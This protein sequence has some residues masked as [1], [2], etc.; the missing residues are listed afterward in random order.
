MRMPEFITFTGPDDRTD[1]ADLAA[2]LALARDYPVE[3]AVLFSADRAGTAR[4][5]SLDWSDGVQRLG[6]PRLAAHLCGGYAKELVATGG[7]G[8]DAHLGGFDRIQVNTAASVSP[9]LVRAWTDALARRGGHPVEPILQCRGP[10]PEDSR[11]T[12]LYDRS[13]GKGVPP[14]TW[15][16]PAPNSGRLVGYAGGLGPDSVAAVLGLLSTANPFYLDMESSLRGADDRFDVD[17]CRR[18]CTA[19]FGPPRAAA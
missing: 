8:L 17:L 3:Y 19:V 14:T 7:S 2:M 4:Y 18:V 10:F 1:A 11:V 12:W 6:F 15:P 16:A 5:P 13:G 9:G